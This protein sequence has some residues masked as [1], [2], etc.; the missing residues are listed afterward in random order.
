MRTARREFF[1]VHS[2]KTSV[3]ASSRQDSIRNVAK[4]GVA[5]RC[6]SG[7]VYTAS[8]DRVGELDAVPPPSPPPAP[9]PLRPCAE[10]RIP[11]PIRAASGQHLSGLWIFH[12]CL[13]ASSYHS[14]SLSCPPVSS[15]VSR[16]NKL[17]PWRPGGHRG[18]QQCPLFRPRSCRWSLRLSPARPS[19]SHHDAKYECPAPLPLPQVLGSFLWSPE[20]S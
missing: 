5:T 10:T 7:A 2:G 8:T 15:P 13:P 19:S 4:G 20:S 18:Q 16:T 3:V 14:L 17:S 1:H 12:P 6:G 9:L 11:Q